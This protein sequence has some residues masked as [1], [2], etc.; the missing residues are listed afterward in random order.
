MQLVGNTRERLLSKVSLDNFMEHKVNCE[1]TLEGLQMLY[2]LVEKEMRLTKSH[3]T[4]TIKDKKVGAEQYKS[5][6]EKMEVLQR[7]KSQLKKY[8][9]ELHA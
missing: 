5:I 2:L 6:L 8:Y 4:D 3:I 1:F 7:T 9:G